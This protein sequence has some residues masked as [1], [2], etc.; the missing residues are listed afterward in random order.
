M[1]DIRDVVQV[2]DG[3][4]AKDGDNIRTMA[5]GYDRIV[6]LGDMGWDDFQVTVPVTIHAFPDPNA[7]GVGVVARWQGHFQI[8]DEQPGRGWWQIGAYG[9]YRNRDANNGGPKLAIYTGHYD[10]LKDEA[11]TGFH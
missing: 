8:D 2:V 10:I 9:F 7:G 11:A 4:W 3:Q 6:A 5:T 1:A